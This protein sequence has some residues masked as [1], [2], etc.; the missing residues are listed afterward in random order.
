MKYFDELKR[1]MEWL[2]QQQKT[3]FVGQTVAGP[4]TFMFQTLRDCPKDRCLEMPINESF[5]MQ[6]TI[7]LALDGY[8]P[9]SVYPRQNFLMLAAG[10][11][12]NVLDKIPAIS[13]KQWL[14]KVLIRVAVGPDSPV[15]PGHQHV[16]NYA[17]AFREMFSW[18]EVVELNEPEEIF[19]AY[20]HALERPDNRS[21]MLIEHG[22][23][24]Q[25]K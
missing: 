1:T 18:I 22:N 8:V 2:A 14:P 12:A 4:G 6:F 3:I 13:S 23:Y 9:I 15:H 19:S 25:Q 17:D 11:M 16:G 7:G 24:Y 21:T 5:Q 20:K 10:D